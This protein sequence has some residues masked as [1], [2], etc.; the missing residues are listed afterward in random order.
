MEKLKAKLGTHLLEKCQRWEFVSSLHS[1]CANML[2]LVFD[3]GQAVTVLREKTS[4]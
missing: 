3:E 2:T 4:L 1:S